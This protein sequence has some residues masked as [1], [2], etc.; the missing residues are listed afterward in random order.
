MLEK[1]EGDPRSS[2]EVGRDFL[3]ELGRSPTVDRTVCSRRSTTEGT[4]LPGV[5]R[6]T[7]YLVHGRVEGPS[8]VLEENFYLAIELQT[9]FGECVRGFLFVGR[10]PTPKDRL[11]TP[12]TYLV[13]N[14]VLPPL[15][16][17]MDTQTRNTRGDRKGSS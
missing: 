3:S 11:K 12:D 15:D 8:S 5:R 2:I 13:R 6:E 16:P 14:P 4:L 9:R 1:V 10:R 7:R 17:N